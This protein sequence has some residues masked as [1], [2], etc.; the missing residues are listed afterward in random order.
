MSAPLAGSGRLGA[1]LEAVRAGA[2][3]PAQVS[4]R[5]AMPLD[6][7]ELALDQLVRAGALRAES[8]GG[9]C[10]TGSCDSC[11]TGCDTAGPAATGLRVWGISA[12]R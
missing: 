8:I 4:L 7:V 5:C 1:V 9:G 6:L 11:D 10:P 2:R 3:T 12:P